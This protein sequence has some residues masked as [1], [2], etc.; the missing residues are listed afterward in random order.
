MFTM[1]TSSTTINWH[2]AMTR[3]AI[4][5][6]PPFLPGAAVSIVGLGCELVMADLA[7]VRGA[8]DADVH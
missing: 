2:E 4:P 5:L 6:P 7:L 3:S 1:V 8:V